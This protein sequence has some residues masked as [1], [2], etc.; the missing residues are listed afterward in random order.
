MQR[1]KLLSLLIS[2]LS[3]LMLAGCVGPA[4]LQGPPGPSGPTGPPGPAG[5]PGPPREVPFVELVNPEGVATVEPIELAPRL[6]TLEGKTVAL[7]W[8]GKPNGDVF[9][10][11]IAEL[12]A[13]EVPTANVIKL[14]EVEP[15]TATYTST[16]EAGAQMAKVVSGYN[17]D[18]VIGAQCD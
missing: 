1:K 4:G 9:L 3:V 7:R 10:D 18:I 5:P 6:S 16:V 17:P 14:Y 8:N 13:V 2:S 12:L 11:R 15:S